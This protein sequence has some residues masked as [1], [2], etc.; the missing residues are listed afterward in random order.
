MKI[1][2]NGAGG[3]MGKEVV[4]LAEEGRHGAVE[5]A[6]VIGGLDGLTQLALLGVG[7]GVAHVV[8]AVH[9]PVAV[10][11]QQQDHVVAA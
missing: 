6:A 9:L 3:R 1:I 8:A 2:I 4:R 7:H 10:L 11:H 5:V